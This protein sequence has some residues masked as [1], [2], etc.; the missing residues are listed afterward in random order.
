M[1][2]EYCYKHCRLTTT[3]TKTR[4]KSHVQALP[5][6][7]TFCPWQLRQNIPKQGNTI[8]ASVATINLFY[9]SLVSKYEL[10]ALHVK[11]SVQLIIR[12]QK[13]GSKYFFGF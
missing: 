4:N 7:S 10:S 9:A 5:I 12:T 6:F 1:K 3:T 11:Y 13:Q 8:K 2:L